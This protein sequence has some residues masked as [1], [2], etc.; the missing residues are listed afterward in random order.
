MDPKFDIPA[1]VL[2]LPT[3][4][5][6]VVQDRLPAI[7]DLSLSQGWKPHYVKSLA[8]LPD[9]VLSKIP[10]QGMVTFHPSFISNTFDG[11][12]WSP[13]L[14]YIKGDSPCILKNRTYYILD[15]K[16]EPFLP[17]M[18]GG[19]GAKL[20]AFFNVSPEEMFS[21]LED[22][23]NS[24]EDVP[25]FVEVTDAKG[26]AR[27]AYYGNY[28]QTRWSDKLDYD[29]MV[30]KVPHNV[31]EYW[32]SELTDTTREEWVTSELKKHFF[33]KPEYEGRLFAALDDE[34][35]IA[36]AEEVKLN[37]SMAKDVRKHVERLREWEREANMKTVMM[38]KQ[39]I[40]DAFD[41]V[42]K[43]VLIFVVI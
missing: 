40:L 1:A 10:S 32:A 9:S 43:I 41:A 24:Y 23:S 18:P 39:F 4:P 15:P 25:M 28:S 30:S 35:T 16:T 27:Y 12:A 34:T 7:D 20:S 3:T 2:S 19:H 26:R 22:D 42:S 33:R 21:G 6:T 36:S 11:M 29:T 17:D 37:E 38:K 31:K 8:A 13:G 14:R 5:E